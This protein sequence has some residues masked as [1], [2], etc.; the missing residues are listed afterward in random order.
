[1]AQ[2][3]K[4]REP[5]STAASQRTTVRVP[6]LIGKPSHE[7]QALVREA[8][9]ILGVIRL[10]DTSHAGAG[11]VID[12]HPRSSRAVLSGMPVDLTVASGILQ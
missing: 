9:L 10:V 2:E 6:D 12:Q 1:V 8:G 3:I 7:A 11:V 5:T 4:D